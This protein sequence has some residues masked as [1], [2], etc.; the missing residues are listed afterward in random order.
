MGKCSV[1]QRVNFRPASWLNIKSIWLSRVILENL[2]NNAVS[3][4][5]FHKCAMNKTWD[6]KN[7]ILIHNAIY[8]NQG[9]DNIL[10]NILVCRVRKYCWDKNRVSH[11]FDSYSS[12]C[13]EKTL[14]MCHVTLLLTTSWPTFILSSI[15][16]TLESE[17]PEL[18]DDKTLGVIPNWSHCKR[19]IQKENQGLTSVVIFLKE[20]VDVYKILY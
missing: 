1:V 5:G 4:R 13:I 19:W 10:N 7:E 8:S 16:G 11:S 17:L 2:E 20:N 3:T 9:S 15:K 12:Q 18:I 14:V 6:F